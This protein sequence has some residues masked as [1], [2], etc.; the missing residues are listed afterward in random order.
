MM[1]I[2]NPVARLLM[3]AVA[4]LVAAPVDLAV[5]QIDRDIEFKIDTKVYFGDSKE[6]AIENKT[7]FS[8]GLIFDFPLAA[9]NAFPDEVL[10]YDSNQKT[11]SLLDLKRQLQ[12]KLLDVQ[13]K[14]MVEGVRQQMATD[15]RSRAM[16][17]Q[18]FEEK[19]DT[20]KSLL[21]LT[22]DQ[23][24]TYQLHG[25]KPE[26]D[27]I[28]S[29]YFEFLDVFTRVQITDPKKLPPFARLRL[30]ESIRRVGWIPDRVDINVGENAF[31]PEPFKARTEHKLTLAVTERDRSEIALA[32]K[33]WAVLPEVSLTKYRGLVEKK[34]FFERA[35]EKAKREQPVTPTN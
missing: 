4:C 30:N 7:I 8:Q 23:D 21:T 1:S 12:L 2:S 14:K 28:L 29:A 26:S 16:L 10:V 17:E 22:G 5:A 27:R 18:T 35:S 25:Q 11:I 20:E 9:G 6:S 13:L 19:I 24:M 31:F 15:D 33:S 34:N 32:K 3:I